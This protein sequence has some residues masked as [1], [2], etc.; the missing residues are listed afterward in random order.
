MTNRIKI[1]ICFSVVIIGTKT[2]I[3]QTCDRQQS[4]F[5]RCHDAEGNPLMS[6][7]TMTFYQ[8]YCQK[9]YIWRGTQC[10]IEVS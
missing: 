7:K 10:G 5:F 4:M 2:F 8:S 3:M 1:Q 6:L 9:R